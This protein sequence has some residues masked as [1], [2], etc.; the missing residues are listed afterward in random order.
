MPRNRSG[1]VEPAEEVNP[2]TAEDEELDAEDEVEELEDGDVEDPQPVENR[3]G[4]FLNQDE[5]DAAV[6]EAEATVTQRPCMCGCGELAGRRAKFIPGHDAK[7]KSRLLAFERFNQDN[8]EA[9]ESGE[10]TPAADFEGYSVIEAL[11]EQGLLSHCS[12]CGQP[13]LQHESGMGP[14][15]RAQKCRCEARRESQAA[16]VAATASA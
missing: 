15:C 10:M 1:Q 13:M 8:A 4:T 14:I 7:L 11:E 16:Q 12:C 2:S 5:A 9:L 6:A 3:H